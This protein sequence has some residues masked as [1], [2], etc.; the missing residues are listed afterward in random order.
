MSRAKRLAA[1]EAQRAA[2]EA[3][4]VPLSDLSVVLL[5]VLETVRDEAGTETAGRV[6]GR[7]IGQK[8]RRIE[9]LRGRA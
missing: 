5:A 6:A 1:L 7:L 2:W 3:A 4:H 8:L 9:A